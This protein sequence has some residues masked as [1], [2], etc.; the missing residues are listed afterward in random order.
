MLSFNRWQDVRPLGFLPAWSEAGLFETIDLVASNLLLPAAGFAFAI[1]V[2][3]VMT[4]SAIATALAI[5][6]ARARLLATVLRWV[7]PAAILVL[8]LAGLA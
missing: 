1:F 7:A 4:P 5:G 3:F 2:G 6:P 8:F